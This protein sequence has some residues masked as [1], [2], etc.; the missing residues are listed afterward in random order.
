M[1]FEK[2]LQKAI[3]RGE[4]RNAVR[5]HEEQSKALSSEEIKR[6]HSQQRLHLS[7]HIEACVKRL[8]HYFPGFRFETIYGERGWGA[9]CSRDDFR[10]GAGGQRA[11]DYSRLE[12]TIRPFSSYHVLD[13][14]AKATIRNKEVFNRNY[15][16]KVEEADLAAFVELIDVWVL[17]YAELYAAGR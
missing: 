8:P 11:N 2:R 10:L 9:A 16:E 5:A 17:E 13:L 14:S 6:L 12:V 4:R 3:E 1:D 15:F 7:E